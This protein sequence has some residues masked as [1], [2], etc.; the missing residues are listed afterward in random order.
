[1]KQK[2]TLRG[3][4]IGKTI[5]IVSAENQSLVGVRGKIIDE[6]RNMVTLD[7]KKRLIKKQ[8]TIKMTIGNE[9]IT[10]DGKQ[11]VGRPEDRLK[12]VRNV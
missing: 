5:E 12:K 8:I 11:L 10:L 3:E 4:L 6:T 2:E 7:N 9:T 1:M